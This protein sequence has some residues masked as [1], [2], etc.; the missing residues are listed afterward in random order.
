MFKD[1]LIGLYDQFVSPSTMQDAQEAFRS[2]VYKNSIG[3]Q[4]FYD[5]LLEHAHNMVVYP[6]LYTIC[7][8]H[9]HAF[10]IDPHVVK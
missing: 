7:A 1:V 10:V 3:V 4:G 6:D 8:I 5:I 9:Q 2:M